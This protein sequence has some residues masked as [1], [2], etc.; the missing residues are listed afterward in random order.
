MHLYL[1]Y[2]D[3]N[4]PEVHTVSFSSGTHDWE[5]KSITVNPTHPIKTALVLLEFHQPQGAAWFDDITLTTGNDR[6]KNLLAASSFEDKDRHADEAKKISSEYE[7]H[8]QMFINEIQTATQTNLS[9][10]LI[11]SFELELE[12]LKSLIIEKGL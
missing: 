11:S 6:K 7:A 9:A 1:D 4:W 12:K 3:G 5:K 2:Q 8:V 10:D